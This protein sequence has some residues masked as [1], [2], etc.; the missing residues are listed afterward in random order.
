MDFFNDPR[1]NSNPAYVLNNLF[2]KSS[3]VLP[4]VI[5]QHLAKVYSTLCVTLLFATLGCVADMNYHF[6][7][8]LTGLICLGLMFALSYDSSSSY[9][10]QASVQQSRSIVNGIMSSR[11]TSAFEIASNP[12]FM[13]TR[14]CALL[15]AF[16]FFK[17]EV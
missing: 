6:G 16:G 15:F 1:V 17:G 8:Q 11:T 3:E 12:I 10:G 14:R 9:V 7:G 5:Q 4:T 13:K 2:S